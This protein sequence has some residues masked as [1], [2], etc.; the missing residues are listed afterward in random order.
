M[1]LFPEQAP[2]CE[3]PDLNPG[4]E[5]MLRSMG[6][7]PEQTVKP[8]LERYIVQAQQAVREYARPAIL[9]RPIETNSLLADT[10]CF[11]RLKR[12]I[13]GAEFVVLM[14][15]TAGPEWEAIIKNESDPMQAYIYSCAAIAI[16][17]MTLSHTAREW[18]NSC[19]EYSIQPHLSPGN[20]GLP[21]STQRL[22]STHLQLDTIGIHLDDASLV[23]APM[24]SVT[25]FV[26]IQQASPQEVSSLTVEPCS[27]IYCTQ[28]PS[29]NCAIRLY[30]RNTTAA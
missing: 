6:I 15:G 5:D 2:T 24:A 20:D 28:C 17:R 8:R 14:A 23:M 11:R 19:P 25:A 9:A 7:G 3:Y 4:R 21:L 26:A 10:A 30:S 16:A 18:Q 13:T 29:A 22:I 27:T 1:K 12:Y